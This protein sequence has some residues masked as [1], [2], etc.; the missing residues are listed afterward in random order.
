MRTLGRKELGILEEL[1]RADGAVVS[2]PRHPQVVR[3][4]VG[5]AHV[6]AVSGQPPHHGGTD[7][8]LGGD[9]QEVAGGGVAAESDCLE[10]IGSAVTGLCDDLSPVRL[11][12]DLEL[13]EQPDQS[14]LS[15]EL[16]RV[17]ERGP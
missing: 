3:R 2:A 7:A 6:E 14:S 11:V 17:F 8:D 9:V 15:G 5:E 16:D 12:C 13:R 1:K 4:P 10:C